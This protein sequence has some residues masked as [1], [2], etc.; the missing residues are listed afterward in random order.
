VDIFLKMPANRCGRQL[1]I[2]TVSCIFE[3][4]EANLSAKKEKAR[5]NARVSRPPQNARGEKGPPET[6]A[7]RPLETLSVSPRSSKLRRS[8]AKSVGHSA[9]RTRH[10]AHFSASFAPGSSYK[11]TPVV[12]K[13]IAKTAVARNTLKRRM[14]AAFLEAPRPK[15]LIFVRAKHGSP[16]LPYKTL[17]EEIFR[18]LQGVSGLV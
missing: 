13:K 11:I 1:Y 17:K 6:P 12:S 10:V 7:E 18:L 14:R 8:D 4:H 16:A 15:A 3:R 9:L 5:P 2:G